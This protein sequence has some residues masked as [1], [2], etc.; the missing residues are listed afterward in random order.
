MIPFILPVSL[1]IHTRSAEAAAI[2]WGWDFGIVDDEPVLKRDKILWF[3]GYALP[4]L[5][6]LQLELVTKFFFCLYS[7]DDLLQECVFEE[8][9]EFFHRWEENSYYRDLD[10][11]FSSVWYA[12]DNVMETMDKLSDRPWLGTLRV[13]L[14]DYLQARRWEYYNI[15]K[16]I[17]PDMD[18]FTVQHVYGSGIYLAIHF[19][20]LHFPAEEYPIEW[21]EQRIARILCLSTDLKAFE[22]HRKTQ[23]SQNELVLLRIHT[24]ISDAQACRHAVNLITMMLDSLLDRMESTRQEADP[25]AAW[26]DQ[27]LLLLGGCMYWSEEDALRYGTTINGINKT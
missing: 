25:R 11:P 13:Y 19:L 12:L 9:M 2:D 16:G 26:V 8:A 4:G 7:L 14:G 27:L 20:K 23:S 1:N 17:I 21:A 5:D 18:V 22:F 24:G 15:K 10:S 3:A 6:K